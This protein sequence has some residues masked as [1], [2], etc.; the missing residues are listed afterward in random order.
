[1]II[2]QLNMHFFQ[3]FDPANKRYEV[4]IDFSIPQGSSATST[5]LYEVEKSTIGT[6]FY[7]KVTRKSTGK[8]M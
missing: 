1:M 5:P 4:P 3:I 6:D 8:V 7:I 2:I